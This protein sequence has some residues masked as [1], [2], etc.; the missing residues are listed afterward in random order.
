VVEHCRAAID[1]FFAVRAL[2]VE[3]NIKIKKK[4]PGPKHW[5]EAFYSA[6]GETLWALFVVVEFFVKRLL[7]VL[8]GK[9]GDADG[10]RSHHVALVSMVKRC[11]AS[12]KWRLTGST[13][14]RTKLG[15]VVATE[16]RRLGG[17]GAWL[18]TRQVEN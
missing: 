15:T 6:G 11:Q 3:A 18:S 1:Y 14:T 10:D 17:N 12:W 13:V 16:V 2:I 7:K 4:T 9:E 8:E 5:G